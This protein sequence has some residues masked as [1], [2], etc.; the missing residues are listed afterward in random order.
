[1][2][3]RDPWQFYVLPVSEFVGLTLAIRAMEICG[4]PLYQTLAGMQI[5]M[6]VLFSSVLLKKKVHGWAIVGCFR[7]HLRVS[8]ESER[9][10]RGRTVINQ[11]D[12]EYSD[13]RRS[14]RVRIRDKLF[15]ER[16][17]DGILVE[18]DKKSTEW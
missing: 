14:V 7:G 15:Y 12:D 16:Y 5:P 10:V 3:K 11:D 1:M 8:G 13:S 9:G 2:R 6:T 17:F 18:I 4:G